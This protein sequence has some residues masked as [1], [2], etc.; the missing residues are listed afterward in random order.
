MSRDHINETLII[1]IGT[2]QRTGAKS[3]E[4]GGH[5][6][7]TLTGGERDAVFQENNE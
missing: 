7:C 6:H 5:K 3:R 1:Y 4:I 2:E